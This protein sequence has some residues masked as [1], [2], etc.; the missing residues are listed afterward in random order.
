MMQNRLFATGVII[1]VLGFQPTPSVANN[2]QH[3]YNGCINIF[4]SKF[5]FLPPHKSMYALAASD[6][7]VRCFWSWGQPTQEKADENTSHDCEFAGTGECY[8][9]AN[10]LGVVPS[11]LDWQ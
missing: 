8:E 11:L 9:F 6:G 10:D 2:T 5:R 1:A 4:N 3:V 7:S